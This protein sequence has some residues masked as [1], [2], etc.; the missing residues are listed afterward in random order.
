MIAAEDYVLCIRWITIE[1]WIGAAEHYTN[2]PHRSIQVHMYTPIT[3]NPDED[4]GW[5]QILPEIQE[6]LQQGITTRYVQVYSE[7]IEWNY[8]PGIEHVAQIIGR[9]Y[10]SANTPILHQHM[11]DESDMV[12]APLVYRVLNASVTPI[13]NN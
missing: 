2:C 5:G 6:I 7:F 4:Q 9:D 3:E 1:G 11:L 13:P 12:L 10:F 8:S